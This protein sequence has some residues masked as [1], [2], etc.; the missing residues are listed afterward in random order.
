MGW[1]TPN[2]INKS[3]CYATL[4]CIKQKRHTNWIP[5]SA[6]LAYIWVAKLG[7]Q[8]STKKS[9]KQWVQLSHLSSLR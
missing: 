6:Q 5:T 9:E 4:K 2:Q 1:L 7:D 3:P 8:Q